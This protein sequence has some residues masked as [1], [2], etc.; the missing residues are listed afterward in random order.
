MTATAT[1][2]ATLQ[3][4]SPN[5]LKQILDAGHAIDLIDV[6][7]PV[8]YR[9]EHV[10]AARNVPLDTL[11]A[12]ALKG[13]RMGPAD[14]PMYVV[15]HTGARSGKACGVL[16]EAGIVAVSIEGGTPACEQAG[17][18]MI[19]GKQI[20]SL[21]R[22]VRIAA[23][24]LVAAGTLLSVAVSPW[25]LVVPGFVGC[26]LIFAGVTDWCGMGMLLAKMPWNRVGCSTGCQVKPVTSH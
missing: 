19:R 17:L 25:F 14:A 24:A 9:S 1:A 16:L 23:G 10:T 20:L 21:E 3:T 7:T 18:T 12:Q 5:E 6:R 8:E 4:I 11:D 26:G 15:C 22:Q 13:Q 2:T